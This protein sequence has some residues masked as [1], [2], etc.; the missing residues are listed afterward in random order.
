MYVRRLRLSE[1]KI[2]VGTRR[3]GTKKVNKLHDVYGPQGKPYGRLCLVPNN[4]NNIILAN[5][6]ETITW[7]RIS[8]CH[9]HACPAS[10]G[11]LISQ[12]PG[13]WGCL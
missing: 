10:K 4:A 12:G 3:P 7:A 9:G 8:A 1:R 6:S 2:T 5:P 11:P 13:I